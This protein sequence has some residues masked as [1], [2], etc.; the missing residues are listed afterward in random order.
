MNFVLKLTV[1]KGIPVLAYQA[2]YNFIVLALAEEAVKYVS[3]RLIIKKRN[4]AYSWADIVAVMVIL[5]A[6][7]GLSEDI[8]YAVGADAI[9]MLVRGFTMGHVGYGFLMGW[10]YAKSLS[11]GKKHYSIIAVIVP[12]LLHGLYDFSLSPDLIA[13]NDNLV[14]VSFMMAL[15]DVALVILTII[16]FVR[17]RKKERY[18]TS[19]TEGPK[20]PSDRMKTA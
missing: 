3:F 5:G 16:F 18:S 4:A 7:F 6:A 10:F 13:W 12:W 14:I 15:I 9:T 2:I 11:A 8:P 17:S 20:E 1:F 19:L